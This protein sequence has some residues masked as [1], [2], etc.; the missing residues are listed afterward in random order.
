MCCLFGMVDYGHTLSTKRKGQILTVLATECEARGTDATGIAYNSHGRLRIYKKPVPAHQ[1]RILV[2][3]DTTVITGHTRMTTQGNAKRNYNNHPFRGVAGKLPF[4]LAHN[5]ILRND[6]LLK[7]QFKL[8]HSK[9]QTDSYVAAQLLEKKGQLNFDTLRFMAEQL[10]GSFSMTVLDGADNLWIVKGDNPLCLLDFPRLGAYLY[11]STEEVL[12]RALDKLWLRQ[13]KQI[14][15]PTDCGE[16]LRLFPDGTISRNTFDDKN[17]F[18]PWYGGF[19][20]AA[21]F[22]KQGGIGGSWNVSP[23]DAEYLEEIKDVASALGYAPE[24][25]DSLARQGFTPEELEEFLYCGEL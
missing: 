9:I 14:H 21:P 13:E 22:S 12:R 25:I 2:P 15:V 20:D 3:P 10:E 16:L 8:P 24:A 5:G 18:L 23:W 4:A 19:Y 11:A 17:L 1:L 6:D 7:R